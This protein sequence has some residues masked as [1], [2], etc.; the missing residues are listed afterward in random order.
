[1]ILFLKTGKRSLDT[2]QNN[3]WWLYGR[4]HVSSPQTH[5]A[6]GVRVVPGLA[7]LRAWVAGGLLCYARRLAAVSASGDA[8]RCSQH[9]P[10]PRLAFGAYHCALQSCV[11]NSDRNS[12]WRWSSLRC[13]HADAVQC[14]C[15]YMH[16]I[17]CYGANAIIDNEL[18]ALVHE[19]TMEQLSSVSPSHTR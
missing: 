18:L 8:R 2:N 17:R 12:C 11:R 3:I 14:S 19:T 1:M 5:L 7:Q 9:A 6:L 16:I 10:P 13:A 4:V 15:F